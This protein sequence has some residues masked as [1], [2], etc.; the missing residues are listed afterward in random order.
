[1]LSGLGFIPSS[2]WRDLVAIGRG[3]VDIVDL[4][5]PTGTQHAGVFL[6]SWRARNL[7]T[8]WI[9]GFKFVQTVHNYFGLNWRRGRDSRKNVDIVD[10]WTTRK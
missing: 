2:S 6:F 4:S 8:L 7:W 5:T 10:K 9:Y 1:M 3:I